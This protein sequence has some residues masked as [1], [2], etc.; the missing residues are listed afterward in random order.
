MIAFK[1]KEEEYFSYYLDELI[2][3]QYVEYWKY[4]PF[5]F[6]LSEE[7]SYSY[8]K[9]LKTKKKEV[10]KTFLHAHEYT[11]DFLI[12]W[13]DKADRVFTRMIDNYSYFPGIYFIADSHRQSY[14]DVKPAF[15]RHNMT[16]LFV[17]N[18]KW[19]F[20]KYGAY[21]QKIVL[22]GTKNA[23]FQATFTPYKYLITDKTGKPR[24]LKYKPIN[25]KEYASNR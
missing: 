11:P 15:D 5:S 12:Q 19:V 6:K 4:E 1:S 9:P 21:V 2:D 23:L 25:L 13:T 20:E 17:I 10:T 18:Q 16:R 14:V 22:T 24:A 3:L 7:V 8:D